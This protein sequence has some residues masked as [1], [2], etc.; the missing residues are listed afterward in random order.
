M[1]W[2]ESEQNN[3]KKEHNNP[4]INDFSL[5]F[6]ND[7]DPNDNFIEDGNMDD[8]SSSPSFEVIEENK[9]PSQTLQVHLNPVMMVNNDHSIENAEAIMMIVENQ[10]SF[11]S[12]FKAYVMGKLIKP[13]KTIASVIVFFFA[14][15][16]MPM[17]DEV[18]FWKPKP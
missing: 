18:E 15:L 8:Y 5:G 16:L 10:G 1:R 4:D 17:K 9:V 2:Q 11:I 7:G 6:I 14:L 3:N 12:K 13:S